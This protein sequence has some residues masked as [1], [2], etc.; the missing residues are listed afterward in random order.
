MKKIISIL[1]VFVTIVSSAKSQT[2]VTTYP[3][4]TGFS[5]IRYDLKVDD[6]GNKWV[7]FRSNGLG[8]FDGTTWTIYDTLSSNIP[9]NQVNGIT[10]DAANNVWVG[11]IKGVA[12]FDGSVWTTY[13]VI[14]SGLPDDSVSCIYAD[15]TDIWIGTRNGLAKFDGTAWTIYNTSTSGLLT[16]LIQC[17][18]VESS[19]DV[20]VGTKSGLFKKSGSVWS[21]F[22][23][24]NPYLVNTYNIIAIYIDQFN[25]KWISSKGTLGNGV[26]KL[27]GTELRPL[28]EFYPAYVNPTNTAP[29]SISKGPMG[30]AI[31]YDS[32]L[33]EIV[34]TQVYRYVSVGSD[35]VDIDI[36]TNKV[37]YVKRIGGSLSIFCFDY[38]SYTGSA[39]VTLPVGGLYGNAKNTLDI[40]MVKAGLLNRGDL[41]WDLT[42]GAYEVPKGSGRQA[43]FASALWIGGLDASGTLHQAAMTYRQTG[44][45]FWPGPLDTISGT[46]DSM[47]SYNY[48]RIWK[49][50]REN[51]NEFR[52][53]FALGLVTSGAYTVSDDIITW[54]TTG[55][56]NYSRKLAPFIDVNGDG[57]YNPLTDGD[58]P[59]MKGDQM[60]FWIFN[61]NLTH[62][63]TGGLPLKVEIHASAY[64][65]V[66]GG[67]TDSL[68]ALNYTTFYNYQIFN[69]SSDNYHNTSLGI[70]QDVD[71]GSCTDDYVGCT[72]SL[73]YG[74]VFNGDDVDDNPPTG[75]IP[76]GLKPPMLSSVILN[77][78]LAEPTDGIDNNNNG[79]IDEVGEKNLMTNFMYFNNDFT[80]TG[81]PASA[82]D[83]YNYMNS[84]WK[85]ST[86]LTYGGTGYGTTIPYNFMF[87]G[88]PGD[89]LG[90]SEESSMNMPADRRFLMGC[91]P[92]NLNAGAKTEFDYAVVYT[93]DTVS[94]YTI[95]N[96]YQKNKEDVMRIQQWFAVDS[97][98]SCAF[99]V[100]INDAAQDEN[101]LS[102]YP[103]PAS[104]NITINITSTSKNVSVKI[105]DATGRMVKNM[106]NVKSGENT[107]NV[108]ELE[109]GLY[110][111]NLQDG[112]NSVTKR[113]I[114]Q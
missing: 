18:A 20:Y 72:P 109:N 53:M 99:T 35:Y 82:T 57:L 63:E 22:N 69:R 7:G 91:G 21:N 81:N 44:N 66:C 24:T 33:V 37:W 32:G 27:A 11:T 14:N 114:K 107:I 86:H 76:Y 98:P 77:G 19:G 112:N 23:S 108:S 85:D 40:N 104:E 79:T 48:D 62:G 42:N 17:V 83:F 47:T 73:N 74:S 59:D 67:I 110:L 105:Y 16:N 29:Y 95:A 70:W 34:G 10:F 36:T 103:N 12:K 101:E 111:L 102:I 4:P 68:K 31:F 80:P 65:Y 56:G 75:Q 43:V 100:G 97:F 93:R 28:S 30:G 58:Y 52:Y 78:P 60:C 6:T 50:E 46:T 54:P 13:N 96:L 90:W 38:L 61:D 9:S 113:F 25:D 39:L 71:L 89:P 55:T 41:F 94:T 49:V 45:D 15:N 3:I 1:I 88:I 5:P 51:I 87:D 8:K 84:I 106:E 64:A 92:F 2:G 26:Y